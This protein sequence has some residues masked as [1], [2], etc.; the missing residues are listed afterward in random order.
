MKDTSSA[1]GDPIGYVTDT[2][3]GLY[4]VSGGDIETLIDYLDNEGWD[5]VSIADF[6]DKHLPN[7]SAMADAYRTSVTSSGKKM[8]KF[9]PTLPCVRT[10]I[11]SSVKCC[12]LRSSDDSVITPLPAAVTEQ[13]FEDS[14]TLAIKKAQMQFE[15]GS[16]DEAHGVDALIDAGLEPDQAQDLIDIW[17]SGKI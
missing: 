4:T 3:L 6:I 7:E 12:K 8:C 10:Q 14:L 13:S 1:G 15:A 9:D 16:L 2:A 5:D 17:K 11:C